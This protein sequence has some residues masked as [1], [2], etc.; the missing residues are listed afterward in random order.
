MAAILNQIV[1]ILAQVKTPRKS[2]VIKYILKSRNSQVYIRQPENSC[3]STIL[4]RGLNHIASIEAFQKK[5]V[6]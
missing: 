1:N 6:K 5:Y 4:N 3:N 2:I